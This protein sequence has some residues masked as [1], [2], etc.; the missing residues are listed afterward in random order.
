MVLDNIHLII[1]N[2]CIKYLDNSIE[3]N[4][5]YIRVFYLFKCCFRLFLNYLWVMNNDVIL[6]DHTARYFEFTTV[7]RNS[8]AQLLK[9]KLYKNKLFEYLIFILFVYCRS[10]KKIQ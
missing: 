4:S 10:S 6:R 8:G 7:H 5:D 3:E 9:H 1:M 2:I